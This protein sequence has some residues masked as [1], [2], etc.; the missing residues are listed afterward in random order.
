MSIMASQLS[1]QEE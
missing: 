1:T